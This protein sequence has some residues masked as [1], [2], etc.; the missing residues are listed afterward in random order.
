MRKLMLLLCLCLLPLPALAADG[1]VSVK[2]IEKSVQ[3]GDIVKVDIRAAGLANLYS[4]KYEVVFENRIITF[5]E[6]ELGSLLA[7]DPKPFSNYTVKK[8]GDK[9]RIIFGASFTNIKNKFPES[10]TFFTIQFK[11]IDS[12]KAS[13]IK[14]EKIEGRDYRFD[15]VKLN[16]ENS[17]IAVT[18]LPTKPNLVIDPKELDFGT[19]RSGESKTLKSH[20]SNDAKAGLK[21]SIEPDNTWI[22]VDPAKFDKD[23]LDV[24]ITVK[25]VDSLLLNKQHIGYVQVVTNG[26]SQSIRCRF[27]YQETAIDDLPPDLTI[28][29]PADKSLLNKSAI[30]IKGRTN[31]GVAIFVGNNSKEV[32]EDGSFDFPYDLHEGDNTITVTAKKDTGKTTDKTIVLTLDSMPPPLNVKDPGETVHTSPIWI[33]GATEKTATIKAGGKPIKPDSNGNFRISFDLKAGENKLE[34]IAVDQAGNSTPWGKVVKFIPQE[35]ISIKMWVGKPEAYIN[36]ELRY[37]EV[38]PTVVGGRTFV[39]LRFVSEN[40]R[41]D[42]K[43]DPDTRS[44][45]VHGQN[46]SCTVFIDSKNAFLD[47]IPKLLEAAPFIKGG[48]S[49]VPLRFISQ[50]TLSAAILWD[51]NEKRIDLTLV[52]DIKQ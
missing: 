11:A 3:V 10:G 37:L 17:E 21:G 49:M 23:E 32:G 1:T 38:P 15:I 51:D 25:P 6:L 39:P 28:T 46:H 44:V 24:T 8:D 13:P 27:Y 26:G 36:G 29:E 9:S 5:K 20:I 48:K 50:D 30:R 52:I 42:V 16:V 47:G 41:A 7:N 19:L 31:P 43:W 40:F 14:I 4:V 22:E 2:P 45:T 18:S 34:I 33:E 12:S 35:T